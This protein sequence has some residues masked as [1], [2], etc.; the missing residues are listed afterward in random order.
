MASDVISEDLKRA[1]KLFNRWQFNEA[2]DAFVALMQ[3]TD[4]REKQ[5]LDAL[6]HLSAAF[7][8]IWH[9]GGEPN[10]M[11]SYLTK[12]IQMLRPYRRGV[13]DIDMTGLVQALEGCHD[14]ALRWRRG[15]EELYNRDI[16]PRLEFVGKPVED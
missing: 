13:L 3:E 4:G 7:H 10:A 1:V 15:D 9:K 6:A 5:F 8:R 11:V 16:I 2:Y 14:E 12:G